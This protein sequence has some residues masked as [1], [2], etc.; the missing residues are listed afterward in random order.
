MFSRIKL[1][2][3]DKE[4]AYDWI[5]KQHDELSYIERKAHQIFGALE[6]YLS[7]RAQ[8]VY[9]YFRTLDTDNSKNISKQ[10]LLTGLQTL[11]VKPLPSIEDVGFVINLV[12]E[13]FL[14]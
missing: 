13:K 7:Q 14:K 5:H 6:E 1:R 3:C 2:Q 9:D 8:R 11:R 10:E 12:D 4:N